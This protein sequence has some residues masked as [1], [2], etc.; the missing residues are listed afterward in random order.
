MLVF[1]DSWGRRDCPG[2]LGPQG[3][4][5]RRGFREFRGRQ[6]PKESPELKVR[7][8]CRGLWGRRVLQARLG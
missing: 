4:R 2:Q 1:K 6:V 8:D 3:S 7:R 5:A